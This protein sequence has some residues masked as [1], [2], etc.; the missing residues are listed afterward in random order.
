MASAWFVSRGYLTHV[1]AWNDG[2]PKL[3]ADRKGCDVCG[4]ETHHCAT[5]RRN[6]LQLCVRAPIAL[7]SVDAVRVSPN[8]PNTTGPQRALLQHLALHLACESCHKMCA[9]WW[10]AIA[11]TELVGDSLVSVAISLRRNDGHEM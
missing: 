11:S 7:G 10:L 1:W 5:Q 6:V 3:A 9:R 8:D 2:A 4:I